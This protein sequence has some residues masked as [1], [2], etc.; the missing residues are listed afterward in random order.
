MNYSRYFLIICSLVTANLNITSS[1]PSRPNR[2]RPNQQQS[3]DQFVVAYLAYKI[4]IK[5]HSLSDV[6]AILEHMSSSESYKNYLNC[7]NMVTFRGTTYQKCLLR[8][9]K[10]KKVPSVIRWIGNQSSRRRDRDQ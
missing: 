5:N 4:D 8:G 7:L 6:P 1:N 9:S 10:D 2:P 3:T